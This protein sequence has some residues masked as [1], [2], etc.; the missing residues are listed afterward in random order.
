M[1]SEKEKLLIKIIHFLAE[2]FKEKIVLE[3]GMLLRMFNSPRSTQDVDYYLISTK[4]KKLL[5]DEIKQIFKQFGDAKITAVNLNSRGIFLDMEGVDENSGRV[6]VEINVASSLNL[7]VESVSTAAL[8]N[9]YMLTGRV[10]AVIALP[11]AFSHK[12]AACIERKNMR[13]LYD[14]SIFDVLCA[15]DQNTLLNR[16]KNISIGRQKPRKVS[17]GEAAEILE[18]RAEEINEDSLRS[19]L[20]PIMPVEQRVGLDKIM[21]ASVMRVVQ[22]LRGLFPSIS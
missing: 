5:A 4:S 17:L 22:K 20:Y 13:D 15:F 21:T 1:K 6:M 18:N 8:S 7:P 11:E 16:L 14:L 2:K 3:G 10:V 19:E 12:I 9:Q